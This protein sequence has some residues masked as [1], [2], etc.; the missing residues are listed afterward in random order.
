V[1]IQGTSAGGRFGSALTTADLNGDGISDL[2]VSESEAGRVQLLYG[3]RDWKKSGKLPEFEPVTLFQGEKGAGAIETSLGDFDGDALLEITFSAQEA[4]SSVRPNAGR[5]W[6]LKPYWPT[7]VDIRPDHEPNVIFY[8][9][10]LIVVRVFGDARSQA[11]P[12]EPSSVRLAG[13]PPE[14]HVL[15]DENG[16][17]FPDL[18]LHFD[19]AGLPVAPQTKRLALTA[20]TRAGL[21]IGG[22]DKVEIMRVESPASKQ[23][24]GSPDSE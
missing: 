8:P 23:H 22:S 16:D 9:S 13:V 11:D 21:P 3:R 6:I 19:T 24:P 14:H 12:V 4:G 15:R 17:G 2:V 5:A 10:G 18:T 7:R 1:T 20:R